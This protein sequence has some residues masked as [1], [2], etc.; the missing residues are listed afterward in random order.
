MTFGGVE[1]DQTV[2]WATALMR[3]GF[4]IRAELLE[5]GAAPD[6]AGR[7]GTTNGVPTRG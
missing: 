4:D 5:S 2:G 3:S 6:E 7:T 1:L